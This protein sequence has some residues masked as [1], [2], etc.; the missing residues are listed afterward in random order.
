M[1]NNFNMRVWDKEYLD[2]IAGDRHLSFTQEFLNIPVT[3]SQTVKTHEDDPTIFGETLHADLRVD[4]FDHLSLGKDWVTDRIRDLADKMRRE[5]T[6][7]APRCAGCQFFNMEVITQKDYMTDADTHR[8]Q[9]QCKAPGQGVNTLVCP[10]G[11]LAVKKG[12]KALMPVI[13]GL[14]INSDFRTVA[15]NNTAAPAKPY[16][17]PNRDTPMTAS[18]TAW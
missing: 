16:I 2:V 11:S 13:P 7:R 10:D 17:S 12:F 5:V 9:T 6:A 15:D 3:V 4:R 18:D 14:T 8:M 1:A